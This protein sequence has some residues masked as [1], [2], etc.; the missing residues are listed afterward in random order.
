MSS[1]RPLAVGLAA[2]VAVGLGVVATSACATSDVYLGNVEPQPDG[3]GGGGGAIEGADAGP[4]AEIT[5]GDYVLDY[6]RRIAVVCDDTLAD[7]AATLE[8]SAAAALGLVAGAVELAL[9]SGL[10][11]IGG[12]AIDATFGVESLVLA[13]GAPALPAELFAGELDVGGAAPG[14]LVRIHALLAIDPAL[15]TTREILGLAAVMVARPGESAHCTLTYRARLCR[16]PVRMP[17]DRQVEFEIDEA[18][19]GH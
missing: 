8:A 6:P 9:P 14:G 15:T 16:D 4:P 5:A 3:G 17:C 18:T 10:I 2:L 7:D 11:V 13:Q 12:A 1:R 19:R